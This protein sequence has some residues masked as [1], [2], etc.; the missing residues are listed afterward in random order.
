MTAT[1]NA[2]TLVSTQIRF[3][4]R[5][6]ARIPVAVFF[7]L[8]LPLVMLVLI[9]ALFADGTVQT[10]NG[11]WPV[12]QFFTVG[13]A[14]FAAVSATYTNF[15]NIIPVRRDQGS[16][17]RWRSTPLPAWAYVAGMI[18]SAV[19][20]AFV[21]VIVIL[22][23]GVAA[24]G[25]EIEAAKLPA[26]LLVLAVGVSTFAALGIAIGS[27]I[28]SPAAAPAI[29]NGT[30]LPL[31]FISNVFIPLEDPPAWLDLLGAFFP[32]KTFVTSFQDAFN[33]TVAAPA[34]PWSSLAWL[35]VWGIVG[36]IGA[37][38]YFSWEPKTS[39]SRRRSSTSD[40]RA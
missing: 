34:I 21:G 20:I 12:R 40:V 14:A 16:L 13:L 27:M 30:I 6:F 28:P 2:R 10:A 19:V 15:A 37:I 5:T 25:L 39:A 31:A 22:G 32:L 7:T 11:E 9:N 18:G 23:L 8:A 1:V 3:Q 4:I 17:K 26:A 35:S 29:A 33:P 38:R 24:Y 36:V